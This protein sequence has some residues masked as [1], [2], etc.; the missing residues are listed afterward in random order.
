VRSRRGD[1]GAVDAVD[2]ADAVGVPPDEVSAH[3]DRAVAR[4][5]IAWSERR[6]DE[7]D[8]T[9][10][11]ALSAARERDDRAAI[12]V[13]AFWRRLAGL[14]VDSDDTG[15]GLFGPAA[16]GNWSEAEQTFRRRDQPY[17]AALCLV[18]ADDECSLRSAHEE[19]LR[20]GALPASRIA[21][22]RLREL[23]VRGLERGPRQ[24]T[25]DHPA[26]LTAREVEVLDL[27]VEGL[28]NTEMADRLVIS[29]R[30]VDHHVGSIMRKLDARTRGEAVA[31]GVELDVV[32]H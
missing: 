24:T 1:P 9:T 19:L 8:R 11:E 32:S 29:R 25:Q 15:S 27:L 17:E 14:D 5:E 3:V 26:G 21:A 30:T 20:I 7:V 18:A 22:R 23:G 31:R 13:L 16:A 2:E 4:A 6:I 10:S 12:A 28:R